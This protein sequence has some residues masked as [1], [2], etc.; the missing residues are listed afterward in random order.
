MVLFFGR[1]EIAMPEA[2]DDVPNRGILLSRSMSGFMLVGAYNQK[3]GS[4]SMHL[5]FNGR[6][7]E[8]IYR[9]KARGRAS[10]WSSSDQE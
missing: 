2:A 3:G 8:L 9:L 4:V 5:R 10:S 6:Y 1:A 7:F